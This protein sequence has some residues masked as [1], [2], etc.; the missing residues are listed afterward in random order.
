MLKS[1][2]RARFLLPVL[3]PSLLA[4]DAV[5]SP[6]VRRRAVT[7]PE[8]PAVTFYVA[9][10]GND[11]WSG[12]LRAPNSTSTDGPFATFDHARAQVQT[13]NKAGVARVDVLFRWGSYFLPTTVKFTAADSGSATT[14]IVYAK[15]PGEVPVFSGGI[16]VQNWTNAGGHTWE[17]SRPS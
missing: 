4:A 16:R 13:L 10:N 15:Y 11:S 5:A 12:K 14:T 8:P 2:R 3:I 17:T 6:A 1:A 7:P 9:T